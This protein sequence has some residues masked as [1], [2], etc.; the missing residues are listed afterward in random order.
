MRLVRAQPL[1]EELRQLA[2]I[3]RVRAGAGLPLAVHHTVDRK[4]GALGGV[5][6]DRRL[7]TVASTSAGRSLS[8]NVE[9][10]FLRARSAVP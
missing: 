1:R 9:P 7:N 6:A 3:L 5:R 4:I 10:R 2:Q 8:V